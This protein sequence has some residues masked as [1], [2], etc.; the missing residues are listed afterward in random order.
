MKYVHIGS[1]VVGLLF[2][3]ISVITPMISDAVERNRTSD[4]EVFVGTLG[5]VLALSPPA[6]CLSIDGKVTFYSFIIPNIIITEIGAVLL[7]FSIW[8]INKVYLY[9]LCMIV[10]KR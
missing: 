2:P 10:G 6:P 1:V 4:G 3:L 9:C 8:L 7:I 5:F